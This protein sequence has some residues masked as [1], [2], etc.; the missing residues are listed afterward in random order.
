MCL[1]YLGLGLW[2][3]LTVFFCLGLIEV[4]EGVKISVSNLF[5][6]FP[7]Q[8]ILSK[9]NPTKKWY[10]DHNSG[11]GHHPKVPLFLTPPLRLMARIDDHSAGLEAK[12]DALQKQLGGHYMYKY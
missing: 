8:V 7:Y 2:L 3:T 11:V 10:F 12:L 9:K 6:F 5:N 1:H 4:W